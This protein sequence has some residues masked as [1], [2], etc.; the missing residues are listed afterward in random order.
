M[1]ETFKTWEEMT[2]LEQM[3]C[4]YWDMYKDAY[5]IRPRGMDTSTWTEEDFLKEFEVLGQAIN[6]AEIQRKE[7]EADAVR[8]FEVRIQQLI[9]C[10][11]RNRAMAIRWLHEA[12]ETNGDDEYLAWNLG[13][14]YG[15]FRKVVISQQ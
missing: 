11:A 10:G 13:L 5:G 6:T 7:D 4:Q 8:R 9:E 15:F 12:Y 1:S 2:T 3:A 14:P